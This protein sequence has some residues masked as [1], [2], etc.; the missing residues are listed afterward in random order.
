MSQFIRCAT[1]FKRREW[2]LGALQDLGYTRIE[3]GR[4][5]QVR[6]YWSGYGYRHPDQR[7]EIVVRRLGEGS[8]SD[9]GFRLTPDGYE[10]IVNDM[11]LYTTVDGERRHL[12]VALK[13]KYNLRRVAAIARELRGSNRQLGRQGQVIRGKIRF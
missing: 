3:E 2:L 8:K 13:T 6:N 12:E 1:R 11:D 5:L 7:A 9:I 10:L 4:D